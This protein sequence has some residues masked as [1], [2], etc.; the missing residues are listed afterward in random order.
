MTKRNRHR[1]PLAAAA[2]VLLLP[3]LLLA[4]EKIVIEGS[5]VHG[6]ARGENLATV[7][8]ALH[9]CKL[10]L[11]GG[12]RDGA[13]GAQITAECGDAVSIEVDW[14]IENE[15]AATVTVTE[16]SAKTREGVGVGDD[17]SK[18]VTA[19][20]TA[21]V[22]V[23]DGTVCATFDRAPGLSF[24]LTEE[25][26]AKYKDALS[27]SPPKTPALAGDIDFIFVTGSRPRN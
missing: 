13:E 2:F 5:G 4:E 22:A 10:N 18:A 9:G 15:V 21:N 12:P 1:L 8:S 7:V 26:V 23:D 25:A 20:G 3:A 19:Y 11:R 16:G 24:C 27:A 6:V 14:D 17:I